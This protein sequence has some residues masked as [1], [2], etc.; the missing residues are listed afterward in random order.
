MSGTSASRFTQREDEEE[1]QQ[2]PCVGT[3]EIEERWDSAKGATSSF[4]SLTKRHA[5]DEDEHRIKT[6]P[7]KYR[8]EQKWILDDAKERKNTLLKGSKRFHVP[9]HVAETPGPASYDTTCGVN[10]KH[11]AE[12]STERDCVMI[13]KE[14]R[15]LKPKS[16]ADQ[17]PGVGTYN[18]EMLYGN[19]NRSTYNITIAREMYT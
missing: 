12:E 11:V 19:L 10:A 16:S 13:S 17:T 5:L 4:E 1:Q 6:E 7:A 8:I 2:S 15:F 14:K 9:K 3:Y 18:P